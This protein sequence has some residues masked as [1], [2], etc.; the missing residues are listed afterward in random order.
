MYVS[1]QQQWFRSSDSLLLGGGGRGAGEGGTEVAV[2]E[3]T[4]S[5]IIKQS[6]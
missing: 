1:C 2:Y 3:T 4:E 6:S 5:D